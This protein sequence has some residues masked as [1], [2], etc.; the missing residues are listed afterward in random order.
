MPSLLHLLRRQYD[1]EDNSYDDWWWSDVRIS[2][3][4][5]K[6]TLPSYPLAFL[7]QYLTKLT[8]HADRTRSPLRPPSRRLRQRDPLPYNLLHPRP[9]APPTG[10][11]T[12]RIPSLAR[13]TPAPLSPQ[14][15]PVRA[16]SSR[17]SKRIPNA[18]TGLGPAT[19]SV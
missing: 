3:L 9:T 13:T 1:G 4:T 14:R 11:P 2:I 10:S 8:P 15:P 18:A 16:L 7:P 5:T 6:P 12:P 17:A 19:T